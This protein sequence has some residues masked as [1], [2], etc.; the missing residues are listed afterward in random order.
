MKKILF[1][2]ISFVALS[3]TTSTRLNAQ[4]T[5]YQKNKEIEPPLFSGN[6]GFRKWSVGFNVGALAPFA[7]SGG[8]NDF[9]KWL[10]T[11][12]YGAYIKYQASHVFGIQ[13]DF[14]RG[15]LEGN[16]EKLQNGQPVVSPYKS[17]NT[18]MN[19]SVSLSG[20]LTFAN[21]NWSQLHTAVQPYVSVGG[22]AVNFTPRTVNNA[23]VTEV[24]APKSN[25]TEFFVPVGLGIKANLSRSINLDL[26]YT[27][28]FV[29]ADNIDGYF[30]A[31]FIGD[32]YS[33]GHIG[34]E[35]ALGR[36]TKPQ[37][38]THNAPAQMAN[39]MKKGDDLLRASLLASEER[40]NQRLNEMNGLKE[41]LQRMKMDSDG[42]GVSDYFDK[43][44]NTPRG[45]KVDGGG[46]TLPVVKVISKDTTINVTNTYVITDEDKR[47]VFD[48]IRNLEF[49]TGKFII[50]TKSFPYLKR[51][52]DL[53]KQKGFR[54]TLGGH[55][56]NVGS[57]ATNMTLSNNRANSVRTYL[58]QQGA[59]A[60][61]IDA[62]GYGE[63]MP[64]ESNKTTKGRQNNRRVEFN[65]Y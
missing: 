26:G 43:C 40:Y 30:K 24:L 23:G 2:C 44:A 34:L 52:A 16:N 50:K 14:V 10:P 38:A 22:G 31:P 32:K 5:S 27:M 36:S 13:A 3:L 60:A 42:D 46:C 12:G 53:L 56:D 48:A 28:A 57:D 8:K 59:D 25:Y 64:I 21:I 7:A 55:T 17:F 4:D 33:Y 54:L 6:S 19:W 1:T 11:L 62:T 65:L 9:S 41:D 39:N 15:V 61:K 63:T 58:I 47:I 29:D 18:D 35:F 51:V 20:V 37:I 45:E 49:E